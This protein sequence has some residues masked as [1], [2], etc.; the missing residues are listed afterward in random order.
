MI[1]KAFTKWYCRVKIQN[2]KPGF[3]S[4]NQ[5]SILEETGVGSYIFQSFAILMCIVLY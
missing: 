2:R 4:M 5:L 1:L 3:Y